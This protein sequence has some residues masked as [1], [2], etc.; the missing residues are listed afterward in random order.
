MVARTLLFHDL[1][2]Q[3]VFGWFYRLA[4]SKITR[5]GEFRWAYV[6]SEVRTAYFVAS[7]LTK[8]LAKT[9]LLS[10]SD[11]VLIYGENHTFLF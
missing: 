4:N 10:V 3:K 2:W 9:L 5:G 7:E 8:I 11:L 1:L 6:W